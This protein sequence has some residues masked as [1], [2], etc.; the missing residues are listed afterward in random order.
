MRIVFVFL[1]LTVLLTS[2]IINSNTN[3]IYTY[4]HTTSIIPGG[5]STQSI[6]NINGFSCFDVMIS[7][8]DEQ[9]YKGFGESSAI[10]LL[11]EA[12]NKTGVMWIVF[13]DNFS[14]G[15]EVRNNDISDHI[16]E[17]NIKIIEN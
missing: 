14:F 12:G 17:Y 9:F 13:I 1:L 3:N 10:I 7:G 4:T 8:I 5:E 2:C 11:D 16:Y 6:V 15:Y